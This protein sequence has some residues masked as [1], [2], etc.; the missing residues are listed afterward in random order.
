[1]VGEGS[2]PSSLRAA[3]SRQIYRLAAGGVFLRVSRGRFYII[4]CLERKEIEN[5]W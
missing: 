1:M 5:N 2:L 3:T 4:R